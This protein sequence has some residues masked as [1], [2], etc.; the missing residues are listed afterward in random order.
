M[1]DGDFGEIKKLLDKQGEAFTEFKKANDARIEAIEKKGAAPADLT[2]KVETINGELT[3]LGKDLKDLAKKAN[4]PG[5]SGG[6]GQLTDD[7]IEHKAAW[8]K[9]ARKG[10]EANLRALERKTMIVG[11]DPDGGFFATEE[12]EA[13]ITKLLGTTVAMMGL[14]TVKPIGSSIYKKRVRI[15]GAGYQWVGEGEAPTDATTP[16]YAELRFEPDT[17]ATEPQVSSESLEDLSISVESEIMDAIE[18]AFSEGAGAAFITGNGVKKPRGILAYPIVANANY[19]WGKVGFINSGDANLITSDSLIDLIHALKSG[20][21]GGASFMLNDLTLA[22]I[23]KLKDGQGDY[24]WQPS[25]QADVAGLLLGYKVSTDDNMP[26]VGAGAYPVAFSD[27]A[28]SYLI[29]RR[30]GIAMLRDPYTAKPYTKFYTTMRITGGIQNFEA[31][32]LLK[33][34]A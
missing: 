23:R 3:Q 29:A 31:L 15:S 18:Q 13:G 1:A 21:R 20:Y 5:A 25:F 12:V 8:Q 27:F 2:E 30:R 33:I 11:S 22:K 24:L 28:K 17:I 14:A 32:K 4:R 16:K 10:E 34:A 9:W 7:Q 26:D 6:D 19:V